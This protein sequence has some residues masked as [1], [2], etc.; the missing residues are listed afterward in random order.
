[1]MLRHSFWNWLTKKYALVND[2]K[3]EFAAI[4]K[5]S[6]QVVVFGYK[7]SDY[8]LLEAEMNSIGHEWFRERIPLGIF[9][10]A[11]G[12]DLFQYSGWKGR[13]EHIITFKHKFEFLMD[14]LP[15]VRQ[16]ALRMYRRIFKVIGSRASAPEI[17][18]GIREV[19]EETILDLISYAEKNPGH[20]DDA[21]L[22]AHKLKVNIYNLVDRL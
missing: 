7:D 6:K 19:Y 4:G 14:E 10:M 9:F 3:P 20:L 2:N 21:T 8:P 18:A 11:K 5:G 15:V 12:S 13:F 22:L 1:M 16:T 17:I